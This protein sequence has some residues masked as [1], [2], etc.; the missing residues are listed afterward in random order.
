[1]CDF[2]NRLRHCYV[3]LSNIVLGFVLLMVVAFSSCGRQDD[4]CLFFNPMINFPEGDLV[5]LDM[6]LQGVVN[7]GI[8]LPSKNQADAEGFVFSFNGKKGQYYKIYYQNESYKFDDDSEFGTEN[9]YGSWEDTGIGFKKVPSNGVV[10]DTFRIV[11]NPRNELKYYGADVSHKLYSPEIISDYIESIKSRP[12]YYKS[13]LEKA[14]K[15]AIL[16]S[17]SSPSMP[18]G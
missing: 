7:Q 12:R 14:K 2:Y 11:G 1:M 17:S 13:I 8:V 5:E 15:T 4:V 3:R 10:V 16:L 6:D 18:C 9:F